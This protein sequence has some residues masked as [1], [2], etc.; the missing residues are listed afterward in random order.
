MEDHQGIADDLVTLGLA[1]QGQGD[2]VGATAL[3]HEALEHAREI[4]YRLGEAT[5]LHRLGRAALDAGDADQALML[6]G[7]SLL[8]V[9]ATGD[10]EALVG[11]LDGVASAAAARS[12][13]RAC[14]LFGAV[15]ALR[16]V[17]GAPRPPADEDSYRR[18]V[19]LVRATLGDDAFAAAETAGRALPL[20]EAIAMALAIVDGLA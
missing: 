6:L 4:G 5:A 16:A 1:T 15:A 11:I 20:E 2:V 13:Q 18:A 7:D 12:V 8:L 14:Q 19:T 17:I 9:R 10:D 3:F